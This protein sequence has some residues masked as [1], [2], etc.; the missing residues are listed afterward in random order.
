VAGFVGA[1]LRLVGPRLPRRGG[2]RAFPIK[3]LPQRLNLLVYLLQGFCCVLGATDP[4][5]KARQPDSPG[6]GAQPLARQPLYSATLLNGFLFRRWLG[7]CS[8]PRLEQTSLGS[9]HLDGKIYAEKQHLLAQ[10]SREDRHDG[11]PFLTGKG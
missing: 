3:L 8:R 6:G 9:G 7:H 11:Y 5:L 4:Q 10:A 1:G 2:R